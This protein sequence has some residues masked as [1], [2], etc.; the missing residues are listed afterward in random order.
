M[1]GDALNLENA[2]GG[3]G[4]DILLGNGSD[5]LLDGGPGAD[6]LFAGSGNDQLYG[7]RGADVLFGEL[8]D[9]TYVFLPEWGAD[10]IVDGSGPFNGSADRVDLSR[11]TESL[12]VEIRVGNWTVRDTSGNS[13]FHSGAVIEQLELGHAAD[14]IRLLADGAAFSVLPGSVDGGDGEDLLNYS[15]NPLVDGVPVWGPSGTGYSSSVSV[16]LLG[17]STGIGTTTD[18]EHVV[19]GS[20]GDLIIGNQGDNRIWSGP[21]DDSIFALDGNDLL[22]GGSGSIIGGNFLDGGA[23]DDTYQFDDVTAAA[24]ISDSAGIDTLDFSGIT[25]SLSVS[26]G[27][28]STVAN[29]GSSTVSVSPPSM[30]LILGGSGDDTFS[31]L[32]SAVLPADGLIDGGDGINSLDYS[33]YA[34]GINV[35]LSDVDLSP[36]STVPFIRAL[37]A[38]G[39]DSLANIQNVLGTAHDDVIVG[40]DGDNLIDAGVGD[41]RVFGRKGLDTLMGGP[42]VNWL[43][44][45]GGNDV[46][47]IDPTVAAD[48]LVEDEGWVAGGQ[49]SSGGSDTVDLRHWTTGITVDLLTASSQLGGLVR[50]KSKDG[51][52][53]GQGNFENVLGSA[54]AVNVL[55]GNDADNLLVGGSLNDTITG[56]KGDDLL[57]GNGGIDSLD[58]GDGNDVILGGDGGDMLDGGIG[59]DILVGGDGLDTIDA[60]DAPPSADILIGGY[61]IYDNDNFLQ[62]LGRGP[63]D[64]LRTVWV[65]TDAESSKQSRLQAG[66]GPNGIYYLRIND[67]VFADGFTDVISN[68]P[69]DWLIFTSTRP[70][71]VIRNGQ[72]GED[73]IER[74]V[75]NRE[76]DDAL[77]SIDNFWKTW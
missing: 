56:G 38:T 51:A 32:G 6:R 63:W 2:Y 12:L 28:A 53:E 65:S 69:E 15:G 37:S 10:T 18:F 11:L 4:D 39:V 33:A 17:T 62:N 20:G 55:T 58:G 21:D 61:T 35:N 52:D 46:Y 59:R 36:S 76:E 41:D 44:G 9:D 49:V 5:N 48:H 64:E 70:A 73:V 60:T 8:G 50:L 57:A 1:T 23:G 68:G 34:T 67:T 7:G 19:G 75:R 3:A 66:V 47:L 74:M 54:T 42:G 29:W 30:E 16:N 13:L 77:V 40:D 22:D 72:L 25:T 71:P 43:F 14:E 45:D 26:F 27:A 24:T 31:L